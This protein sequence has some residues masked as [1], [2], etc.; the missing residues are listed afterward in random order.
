M[1]RSR[2]GALGRPWGSDAGRHLSRRGRGHLG[3][4]AHDGGVS[5]GAGGRRSD[6][7]HHNGRGPGAYACM[8]GART[9][10]RCT[11]VRPKVTRRTARRGGR[12]AGSKK[13]GWMSRGRAYRRRDGA[14]A[15]RGGGSGTM[16]QYPREVPHE[17]CCLLRNRRARRVQVRRCARPCLPPGRSDH[18][19]EGDR[20]PGR[21][22]AQ[23]TER[24][25]GDQAT[26][27][28]LPGSGHR[29]RS[30]RARDRPKAR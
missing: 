26:Y 1:A 11:S 5:A 14:A 23:S 12:A 29:P 7:P 20:H 2:A 30:W 21:R 8:L 27:R 6:G 16:A 13:C 15:R 25:D 28:R 19:G 3:R 24:N 18:R 4:L 9:D 22:H 10:G 17:S